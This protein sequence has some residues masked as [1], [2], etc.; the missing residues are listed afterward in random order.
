VTRRRLFQATLLLLVLILCCG[1]RPV[2]GLRRNVGVT[3][4]VAR[5]DYLIILLAERVYISRLSVAGLIGEGLG[6]AMRRSSPFTEERTWVHAYSGSSGNM[7]EV[8]TQLGIREL[9][10]RDGVLYA[11]EGHSP[12]QYYRW[13]ESAGRFDR[14]ESAAAAELRSACEAVGSGCGF[15]ANRDGWTITEVQ[16]GYTGIQQV[17]SDVAVSFV[18]SSAAGGSTR[19]SA[20]S[21]GGS[22]QLY[23]RHEG[24]SFRRCDEIDALS[25][26][27]TSEY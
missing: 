6:A 21:E 5:G 26:P 1:I 27:S 12:Y 20:Q 17:T 7:K 16:F 14:L 11:A 15:H 19:V 4:L 25:G 24:F 23:A 10:L 3:Y 18:S 22:R 8:S 13:D 2:C 9:L